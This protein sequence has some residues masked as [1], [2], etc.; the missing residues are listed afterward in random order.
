[1]SILLFLLK[2]FGLFLLGFLGLL[3][4]PFLHK[5]FLLYRVY[6]QLVIYQFPPRLFFRTKQESAPSKNPIGFSTNGTPA[7]AEAKRK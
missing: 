6:W 7:T 3:T 1:M 2:V 4:L 5:L